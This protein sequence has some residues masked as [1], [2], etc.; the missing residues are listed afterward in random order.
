MNEPARSRPPLES[1]ATE[2][3]QLAEGAVEK[4]TEDRLQRYPVPSLPALSR[5]EDPADILIASFHW[6]RDHG[7]EWKALQ[8]ACSRL[9]ERWSGYEAQ[10]LRKA[11]EPLGE[12]HYLCARIGARGSVPGIAHVVGREDLRRVPLPG[13]ED[14]QL[15]ALRSLTGLLVSGSEAEQKAHRPVL[16]RA[17]DVPEHRLTGLTALVA[18]WPLERHAFLGS[19]ASRKVPDLDVLEKQL[20]RALALMR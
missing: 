9:S 4:L 5:D 16:I 12:L 18:F 17:L 3:N 6:L 1:L 11:P 14:L 20:D 13:G 2:L 10:I 7:T 8:T 19:L 15:R